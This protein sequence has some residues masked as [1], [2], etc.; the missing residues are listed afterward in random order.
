MPTGIIRLNIKGPQAHLLPIPAL[1]QPMK[2][3]IIIIQNNHNCKH[4]KPVPPERIQTHLLNR[5]R[6]PS[7]QLGAELSTE[8]LYQGGGNALGPVYDGVEGYSL[9]CFERCLSGFEI[10]WCCCRFGGWDFSGWVFE[11]GRH[12][13][14]FFLFALLWVSW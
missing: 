11:D 10:C 2:S 3:F 6:A 1:S 5:I 12:S 4:P 7:L 9:A 13:L 8:E 14:L